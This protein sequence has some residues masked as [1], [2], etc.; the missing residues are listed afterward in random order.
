MR[1]KY[2]LQVSV[3]LHQI[4]KIINQLYQ[5]SRLECEQNIHANF[6]FQI[7]FTGKLWETSNIENVQIVWY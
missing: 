7:S 5:N 4:L 2:K 6:E 3:A 1:E